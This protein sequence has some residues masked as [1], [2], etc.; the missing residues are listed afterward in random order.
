M[1]RSFIGRVEFY[2]DRLPDKSHQRVFTAK[3][4]TTDPR[5]TRLNATLIIQVNTTVAGEFQRERHASHEQVFD[6]RFLEAGNG[7]A[8]VESD[9]I[10]RHPRS[11]APVPDVRN[12][13]KA[14]IRPVAALVSRGRRCFAQIE[15][16]VHSERVALRDEAPSDFGVFR[17]LTRKFECICCFV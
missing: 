17:L 9:H 12:G 14:D 2:G 16:S 1:D 4:Q 15:C 3:R 13:W 7:N 10:I 6:F 8:L 5:A 11:F